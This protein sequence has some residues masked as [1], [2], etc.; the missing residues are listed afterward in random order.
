MLLAAQIWDRPPL[1]GLPSA[2]PSEPARRKAKMLGRGVAICAWRFCTHWL[3]KSLP[4]S[5]DHSFASPR[6]R[7]PRVTRPFGRSLISLPEDENGLDPVPIGHRGRIVCKT[8]ILFN[9]SALENLTKAFS[10][11]KRTSH[12]RSGISP[13]FWEIG[14]SVIQS[15]EF[16]FPQSFAVAVIEKKDACKILLQVLNGQA[17]Y[18]VSGELRRDLDP[19]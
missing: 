5:S 4:P 11:P 9:N 8:I 6:S 19:A 15:C 18:W 7:V 1:A 12:T 17:L 10:I 14:R 13:A 2:P 3:I 16:C